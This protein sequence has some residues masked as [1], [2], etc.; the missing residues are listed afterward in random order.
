MYFKRL[1][2]FGFKSFAEKTSLD[3]QPGITAIVGPNGCGKSNIFDAIRWV[4]GEQSSKELRGSSMEDVIFNGTEKKS[5]LG[6]AEVSL[7]F[8][9]ESRVFAIDNDEVTITRRLFRS[10]ESEYLLNKAQVRLKDINELLMGTGIGAEAYS[11]VQQGRVDLIVNARPEERRF[12]IDE[13][14]GI[15]KYKSKKKEALNKLKDTDNNLLRVNDIVVEVK[16]QI[17]SIERQANKARKYKEE[18][19]KLKDMEVKIADRQLSAFAQEKAAALSQMQE[20]KEKEAKLIADLDELS[21]LLTSEISYLGEIEQKIN[22]VHSEEIKLDGQIDL[23]ERQISFNEERIQHVS[24]TQ[25]RLTDQKNQL[26]ERCRAQQAKIESLKQEIVSLK[27]TLEYSEQ[28]LK[29]KRDHLRDFERQIKEAKDKIKDHEEKILG[30]TSQQ[31]GI[32][33]SLT[34]VM[35]ELQ[36]ALARKRRLEMENEKVSSEKQEVDLKLQNA[37]FQIKGLEETMQ[38]LSTDKQEKNN[39][40]E[41]LDRQYRDMEQKIDD[42]EK[43]KLFLTSQKEFIEKM[44][45]QYQ[46]IPDPVAESRFY[47]DNPP[48]QH[49][50]GMIGKVKQV[51]ALDAMHTEM[52]KGILNASNANPLYEIV[53]ETKFI[54]LDP[55]QITLKIEEI[56][57]E[58][59]QLNI[60]KDQQSDVIAQQRVAIQELDENIHS[61]EK[62]HSILEAQKKDILDEARKLLGELEIVDV[63]LVEIHSSLESL[64]KKEEEYN[65]KLDTIN[66][67]I[68]WCQN[69]IKERQDWITQQSLEKEDA[70]VAIAQLETEINGDI[71]KMK[72]L[73][74][75]QAMFAETLDNWLAEIKKIDDEAIVQAQRKEEFERSI[76]EIRQT[77]EDIRKSQ[78]ALKTVLADY[79]VQKEDL[80]QR[81]NSIRTNTIAFEEEIE[82]IRKEAHV[83]E[84]KLQEMD[85]KEQSL[86]D[87]LLQTYK[88]SPEELANKITNVENVQSQEPLDWETTLQEVEKLRK[89][90]ESYGNVNLVAIEEYEELKQRFEF[91]TKQQADLIEAK[92]Q[93]MNTITK[94]NRT[95]RQMF[96]DTFTKVSEEFRIYFRML[97]GGGEAQLVLMDPENVLESGIEI[98]ARPTG[99]KL[100]N[101]SLLSGGE[102]TLTAI[103]LIFGVFKVNPSPFCVLDEIDAALDESNVGRFSYLVKDFAKIAQFIVIT[104]NKK[105]IASSDVMYGITMPETGVSRIVSV[106][107]SED[108][109][110]KEPQEPVAVPA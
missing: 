49:H 66:Q 56:G 82:S 45:V 86:R 15:T 26:I 68:V 11:M 10:G 62:S 12:I 8:S 6:F 27:E 91:L 5:S 85:F 50:T 55:Q 42:L 17:A 46:D 59:T 69:D 31:V 81:I 1:E 32:R 3:F 21:N 23:N 22:E 44:N 4:L 35:K 13:A 19:E 105:T 29:D 57:Q 36:G 38:K 64:K 93:L 78:V 28:T 99:K 103:A 65:F 14:A 43:R 60:Q 94:I 53:C 100:Q 76:L 47:T 77:L 98:V 88:I 72:S 80:S 96:M 107:F 9:N 40:L 24:E 25:N 74:E 71:E 39:T 89:R 101:I 102:K 63:E 18:F 104:H 2:L 108:N 84:L 109:K 7:T 110:K 70:M 34:D 75:N 20:F 83:F 16:R 95:T 33:N 30:L 90:C 48:L 67:D 58:I 41:S 61:K 92:S 106:K 87:R 51:N 97:F 73:Q 52:F 54:E 37:D 79:Q